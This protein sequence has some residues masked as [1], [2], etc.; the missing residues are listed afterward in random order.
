L[1]VEDVDTGDTRAELSETGIT[2][3]GDKVGDGV[4]LR[5]LPAK[6][7]FATAATYK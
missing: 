1:W 4:A 7:V 5:Q 6:S 2:G 3:H